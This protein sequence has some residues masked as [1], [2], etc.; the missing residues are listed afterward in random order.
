M[1]IDV[2]ANYHCKYSSGAAYQVRTESM[3]L[4]PTA[5]QES[6]TLSQFL[7]ICFHFF[8]V[9]NTLNPLLDEHF[10]PSSGIKIIGEP[11]RYYSA[12]A[13]TLAVNVFAKRVVPHSQLQ[14]GEKAK[15]VGTV[16]KKDEQLVRYG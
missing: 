7:I 10:P 3:W 4:N 5:S 12:S 15:T 8:Q 11:G 6:C 1:L 9:C 13:L 14:E 16:S 2:I